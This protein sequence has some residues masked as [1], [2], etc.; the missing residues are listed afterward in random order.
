MSGSESGLFVEILVRDMIY[1]TLI[2]KIF[3]AVQ[4]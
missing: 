1:H 4:L 2:K 3:W